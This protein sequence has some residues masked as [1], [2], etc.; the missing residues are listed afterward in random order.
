MSSILVAGIFTAVVGLIL[1]IFA[2]IMAIKALKAGDPVIGIA[3]CILFL[4]SLYFI[5]NS[6]DTVNSLKSLKEKPPA[7]DTRPAHVGGEE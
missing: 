5:T 4:F 6:V 7:S 2:Y 1:L 3:A